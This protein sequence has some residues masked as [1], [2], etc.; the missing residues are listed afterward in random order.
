LST[1]SRQRKGFRW[2]IGWGVFN[3]LLSV[4]LIS[5]AIWLVVNRQTVIDWWRLRSYTPSAAVVALA[6]ADTMVGF[7]R[8]MLY[9]SD[10]KIQVAQD[11]TQSCGNDGEQSIVLGCYSNQ[12]IYLFDVT[13]PQLNGV[14]EVTAAHEMLHAAYDRIDSTTKTRVNELLQADMRRVADDH[15]NQLVD[16]YNKTEPGELLNEMHSIL[17]TEYGNLTPELETYYKKYF[18]DRSKVLAFS[19]AYKGV[20]TASQARIADYDRQL[21]S[22]KKQIDANYAQLEEK[23]RQ[24]D[25]ESSRLDHLRATDPPAYNKAVPSYNAQVSSYNNLSN[26][27]KNIVNQYN[28]I[29]AKRNAE[30]AAQN[31]L[32]QSLNSQYQ[33]VQGN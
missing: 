27:T 26:A 5:G 15:L 8:D 7:G 22:L 23:K 12:A 20:F 14:K 21:A 6:D 31:N 16:L 25:A 9:V 30:A 10:P 4:A 13:N 24:L 28:A 11:F 32:Y 3:F 18:A 19:N 33:T 29:V 17:G 2:P 1:A